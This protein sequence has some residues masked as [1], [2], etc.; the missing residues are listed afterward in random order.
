MNK[1]YKLISKH[2]FFLFWLGFLPDEHSCDLMNNHALV[3]LANFKKSKMSESQSSN[4]SLPITKKQKLQVKLDPCLFLKTPR[5]D[6]VLQIQSFL[7]SSIQRIQS[8]QLPLD[9]M[10]I[11]AK[12]GQIKDKNTKKRVSGPAASEC[13]MKADGCHFESDVDI[14]LHH[15]YNRILNALVK[16]GSKT[17]YKHTKT[18]DEFYSSKDGKVRVSTNETDKQIQSCI[19]SKI[20]DLFISC[21][22][23]S[24]DYRISVSVECDVSKPESNSIVNLVRKKD[25]MCYSHQVYQVDLTK[26]ESL[27]TV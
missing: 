8:L 26:V 22:N 6:I 24:L 23:S 21:P 3:A 4:S 18:C 11:E 10:E 13:I 7:I 19:I 1:K 17:V 9:K 5:E 15:H 27:F 16:P 12:L 25:R 20:S 14:S 2:V